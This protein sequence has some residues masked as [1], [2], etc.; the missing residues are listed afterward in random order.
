MKDKTR[1]FEIVAKYADENFPLPK[2]GTAAG[3]G[4]DLIAAEKTIILPREIFLVPT[5]FKVYM[6]ADEFLAVFARSSLPLK[7]KLSLP[8]G[9]G[10]IDA[11]Y[12]GNAKN[13]GQ[14]FVMLYNFGEES[15][16]LKKGERFAQGIFQKYFTADGDRAGLGQQRKGG[17]GSTGDK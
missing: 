2:R 5:P 15:A 8:N 13:E 14:I 1:G 9:A 17:F 6:P 11:D 4:Y 16:T 3:A 12:Y 10:I 7:K